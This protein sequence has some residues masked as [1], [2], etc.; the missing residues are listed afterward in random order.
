M[1]DSFSQRL[2]AFQK[3]INRLMSL[4]KSNNLKVPQPFGFP[5]LAPFPSLF[6]PPLGASAS[7]MFPFLNSQ[8]ISRPPTSTHEPPPPDPFSD[9]DLI[10]TST[11]RDSLSLKG[12]Q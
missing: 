2:T 11:S 1:R 6:D 12:L 5:T 3:V 7:Q 9:T 4:H 10:S 8:A